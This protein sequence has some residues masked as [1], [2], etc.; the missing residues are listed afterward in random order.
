MERHSQ[1][2]TEL[3][4]ME[5]QTRSIDQASQSKLARVGSSS[6]GSQPLVVSAVVCLRVSPCSLCNLVWNP[7]PAD[8]AA[9][10]ARSG[11]TRRWQQQRWWF[12][13]FRHA[14]RT[15]LWRRRE[16]LASWDS[17]E[18]D[19]VRENRRNPG[20]PTATTGGN[21]EP[22]PEDDLKFPTSRKSILF[23]AA[24]R[25][26]AA[27]ENTKPRTAKNTHFFVYYSF[28][29]DPLNPF[30]KHT[31]TAV[32]SAAPAATVAGPIRCP[33]HCRSDAGEVRSASA[34]VEHRVL[35]ARFS[36]SPPPLPPRVLP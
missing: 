33:E 34:P 30:L 28:H 36:A 4:R 11:R 29:D 23:E 32:A 24:R 7:V 31:V 2:R 13:E 1:L 26:A 25:E 3:R 18:S 17:S 35:Q 20:R 5:E 12:I 16:P 10:G 19:P 22:S 6:A 15:E 27:R 14:P 9:P 8:G 21:T